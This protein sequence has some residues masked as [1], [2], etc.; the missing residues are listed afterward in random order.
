MRT[1]LLLA[2]IIALALVALVRPKV[3]VYSI[4][5]FALMRPDV[6]AWSTTTYNYASILELGTLIGSF[7]YLNQVGVLF[8]NS[9]FRM[10]FLLQIPLALSVVLAL[11]PTLC[12]QPYKWYIGGVVSA[13]LI[14]LHIQTEKDFRL[15]LAIAGL[16]IGYLGAKFGLYGIIHG[17]VRYGGGYGASLSDNNTLAL[18]LTMG[19]PLAWYGKDLI[20]SAPIRFSLLVSAF[21]TIAAVIFTFS[22]GAALALGAVF[23]VLILHSRHRLVLVGALALLTLPSLYMVKD[24]YFDRMGSLK[25]DEQTGKKESSVAERTEALKIAVRIWKDY[26]LIGV[27]FGSDNQRM[28]WWNYVETTVGTGAALYVHNTYLQML[29]DSGIFAL[30]AYVALLWGT[31]IMLDI[32][33]RRLKRLGSPLWQCPLAI[34]A[35]LVG[36]AVGSTFLTRIS[37]DFT[38]ILLMMGAAWVTVE[39]EHLETLREQQEQAAAEEE[40]LEIAEARA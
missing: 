5:W 2:I 22:R 19:V 23:L 33:T 6:W 3:G 24:S 15:L 17:G 37:F 36:F 32:S 27:G 11:H 29:V 28:L 39:P 16:S 34:E 26:P 21:L 18:A 8:R 1:F 14:A 4:V 38:Y 31:I 20:R 13:V 9:I 25:T 12:L 30:L 7:K 10:L 35:A 40:E